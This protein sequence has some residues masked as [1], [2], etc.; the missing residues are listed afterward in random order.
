MEQIREAI[1]EF[2][3]VAAK[4]PFNVKLRTVPL[5][6]V[7]TLWNEPSEGARLVFQP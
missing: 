4:Q 6:D 7:E 2:F 3:A 1:R 5:R